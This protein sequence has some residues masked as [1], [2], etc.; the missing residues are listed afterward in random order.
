MTP[1]SVTTVLL[2]MILGA[3]AG[4]G[5][6]LFAHHT[7][8]NSLREC[9]EVRSRLTKETESQKKRIDYLESERARS[10][11][12]VDSRF[13]NQ[14]SE[15]NQAQA[16]LKNAE[17]QIAELQ[18]RLSAYEVNPANIPNST[19]KNEQDRLLADSWKLYLACG[20]L[21]RDWDNVPDHRAGFSNFEIEQYLNSIR[22]DIKHGINS[23][24]YEIALQPLTSR[25]LITK[26]KPTNMNP[27]LDPRA[28]THSELSACLNSLV[29]YA[30]KWPTPLIE[31][32]GPPPLL[33]AKQVSF[34]E[35]VVRAR[36]ANKE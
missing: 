31:G 15:I 22:D 2:A 7:H 17:R 12:E 23:K 5:S 26:E 10:N 30:A 21:I 32:G 3:F 6:W 36:I 11:R 8:R 16:S 4:M 13:A 25:R 9:E 29:E 19:S 14:R 1:R 35:L 24:T 27:Y 20:Y 18:S 28:M 34:D 33:P